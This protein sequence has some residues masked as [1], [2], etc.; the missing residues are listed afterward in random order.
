MIPSKTTLYDIK[1]VEANKN[2]TLIETPGERAS[3][4]VDTSA[5]NMS[6]S[7]TVT[8]AKSEH[9]RVD[10]AILNS[11]GFKLPQTGGVGTVLF[12]MAGC[13]AALIGTVV[14]ANHFRKKKE[15]EK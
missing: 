8:G 2:K 13:G 10:M 3:A 7:T 1:D 11:K 12:T 5:T 9:S 15:D 6:T 14:A 4:T